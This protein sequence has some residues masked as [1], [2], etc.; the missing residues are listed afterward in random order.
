MLFRSGLAW[1]LAGVGGGMALAADRAATTQRLR[2]VALALGGGLVAVLLHGGIAAIYPWALRRPMVL[3]VPFMALAQG[4]GAGWILEKWG[5]RRW[6][7]AVAGTLLLGAALWTGA[8]ISRMASRVGDYRGMS[9][10]LDEVAEHIQAD[11]LVVADDPRWGTPLLLAAG[12]DVV[13]GKLL[14][15]LPHDLQRAELLAMLQRLQDERHGRVLWLTST[16]AGLDIYPFEVGPVVPLFEH[17]R[18]VYPTVIHSSRGNHFATREN[19][20]E[21][22]LYRWQPP[23]AA[24]PSATAESD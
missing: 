9:A 13:N 12:R 16:P 8:R 14:W 20:H 17:R 24:G 18:F 15:H 11:D 5:A 1:L 10:W 23:T 7:W 3:W 4:Y 22:S 6:G 19:E 21:F 2:L